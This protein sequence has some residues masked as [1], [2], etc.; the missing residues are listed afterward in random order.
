LAEDRKYSVRVINNLII[1]ADATTAL[2]I[3]HLMRCLAIAQKCRDDGGNVTFISR[4]ESQGLQKRIIEEGFNLLHVEKIHP[5]PG[6]LDFTLETLSTLSDGPLENTWLIAD[7]YH[8]NTDYHKAVRGEGKK[9]VII[10]DY[11][12]LGHYD[13]DILINQNIGAERFVYSCPPETKL[14]LGTRYSLLRSE[15]LAYNRKIREPLKDSLKILITLGG[16]DPQNVT[17]N[18][19]QALQSLKLDKLEVRIVIGPSNANREIL[20]KEINKIKTRKRN[21]DTIRI[22][23]SPDM[24]AIMTWADVAI[25]A[26]GATCWELAFMGLP[27]LI[28][29]LA[30]NQRAN[31]EGLEKAGFAINLGEGSLTADT[32]NRSLERVFLSEG[33]LAEMARNGQK[34]VDGKGS[35]RILSAMARD[36]LFLKKAREEDCKLIWEW[37]NEVDVRK[38]SFNSRAIAWQ[39]HKKWFD[40]KLKDENCF[41]F[42]AT[43]VSGNALG[44]IRFDISD[45]IAEAHITIDRDI[46]GCGAGSHLIRAGIDKLCD[47]VTLKCVRG[48]VLPENIASIRA[49]KKAGFQEKGMV[50]AHGAK[51]LRFEFILSI[52]KET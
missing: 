16:S 43:D 22:L 20:E 19:I 7:G 8:F 27:A 44:Q 46:R 45:D 24:P 37:A 5:Y 33:M 50:T 3:G 10:D 41:H 23:Q 28:I 4:C 14:L 18:I 21:T 48:H 38:W 6:D 36:A 25:S 32:L 42:I 17:L 52:K 40:H 11:N 30:E 31:A 47:H 35:E 13:A 1:R 49:F 39:D 34:L 9:L 15:F 26:G 2:G 51:C 29:I 12:H